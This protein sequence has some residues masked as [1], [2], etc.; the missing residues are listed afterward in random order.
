MW[1]AWKLPFD[2]VCSPWTP[3][4]KEPF[5]FL[6]QKPPIQ[7]RFFPESLKGPFF[8]SKQFSWILFIYFL[9]CWSVDACPC[10]LDCKFHVGKDHVWFVSYLVLNTIL[11]TPRVL[12]QYLLHRWT[13]EW[14]NE[15]TLRDNTFISRSSCAVHWTHSI[16]FTP[17]STLYMFIP[18]YGQGDWGPQSTDPVQDYIGAP[19]WFIRLRVWLLVLGQVMISGSQ[20]QAPSGSVL[21]SESACDSPSLFQIK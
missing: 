8:P 19:G 3:F 2:N 9:V 10:A 7:L 1:A 13:N 11:S 17:T 4:F 5:F 14:V 12:S 16:S 20:D 21:S 15:W 6:F 18:F